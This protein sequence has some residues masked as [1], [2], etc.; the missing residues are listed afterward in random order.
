M[1]LRLTICL[2][3][4]WK[5]HVQFAREITAFL[6]GQKLFSKSVTISTHHR[7]GYSSSVNVSYNFRIKFTGGY[8]SFL[9]LRESK[10]DLHY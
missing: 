1:S 10:L 5:C 6:P 8:D 4:S 3:D 9:K 2:A 7:V